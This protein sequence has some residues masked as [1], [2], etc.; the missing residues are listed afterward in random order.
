MSPAALPAEP[1]KLYVAEEVAAIIRKGR[2]S[3]WGLISSGEIESFMI[4][5]RRV[6]A[7][8]ALAAFIARKQ[9]EGRA[10]PGD[11]AGPAAEPGQPVTLDPTPIECAEITSTVPR[12]GGAGPS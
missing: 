5:N 4:G 12:R 7:A 10:P 11:G 2:T 9:R 8:S 6:V 3:T 1:E